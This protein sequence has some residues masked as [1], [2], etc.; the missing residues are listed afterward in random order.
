MRGCALIAA[1]EGA[2]TRVLEN[3]QINGVLGRRSNYDGPPRE[4]RN[5]R[6]SRKRYFM[7]AA[8]G[9]LQRWPVAA[10][11]GAA[12]RSS[13]H[14]LRREVGALAGPGSKGHSLRRLAFAFAR[15]VMRAGMST[16]TPGHSRIGVAIRSPALQLTRAHQNSTGGSWIRSPDLTHSAGGRQDYGFEGFRGFTAETTATGGNRTPT[17]STRFT[18]RFR[19]KFSRGVA[20]AVG[21]SGHVWW[22][23]T[24]RSC[25]VRHRC[26]LVRR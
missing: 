20:A 25:H 16:A 11:A 10:H 14:R 2:P 4:F 26:G 9:V 13:L 6:R 5:P 23:Q 1:R 17:K 22:A 19:Q 18:A 15:P 24:E 7:V 8:R 12:G 3:H 21:G